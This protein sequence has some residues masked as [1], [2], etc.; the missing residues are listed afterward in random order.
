MRLGCA[1]RRAKDGYFTML[2]FGALVLLTVAFPVVCWVSSTHE[3]NRS[4]SV[5]DTW[6]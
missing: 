1:S 4:V 2:V 5:H 6:Q 3:W